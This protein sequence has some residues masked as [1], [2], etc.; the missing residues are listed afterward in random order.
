MGYQNIVRKRPTVSS[1]GD[2]VIE[3][4]WMDRAE[5]VNTKNFASLL[6][7]LYKTWQG[8]ELG[9]TPEQAAQALRHLW[10]W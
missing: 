10:C 3:E 6:Q 1:D 8:I 5:Q 4:G 2:G 9:L 7:A